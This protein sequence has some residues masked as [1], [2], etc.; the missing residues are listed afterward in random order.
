M[1]KWCFFVSR[2]LARHFTLL[3]PYEVALA[4]S[5][6]LFYFRCSKLFY[7]LGRP[8][9]FLRRKDTI[10]SN[11][12]VYES[13]ISI[14]TRTREHCWR[15]MPVYFCHRCVLD[16]FL[17]IRTFRRTMPTG[18]VV[19][20][21]IVPTTRLHLLRE[22]KEVRQLHWQGHFII[23]QTNLSRQV[24]HIHWLRIST[25]ELFRCSHCHK[26]K[27]RSLYS[28]R[29]WLLGGDKGPHS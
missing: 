16:E 17:D 2:P 12:S 28:R 9:I 20:S 8:F 26:K 11:C 3:F 29:S 7:R 18:L 27:T 23:I 14:N 10:F 21:K 13:G 24:C 6:I 19:A 15:R 25:F 1:S 4:L 22:V 5:S